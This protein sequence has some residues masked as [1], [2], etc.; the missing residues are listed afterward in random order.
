MKAESSTF[1]QPREKILEILK[2]KHD[3]F[4]SGEYISKKLD[5]SRTMVWK[6]VES[7]REGGY[8]IESVT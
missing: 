7:L 5:I 8:I 3:E 4:V 2:E 1:M 6:H